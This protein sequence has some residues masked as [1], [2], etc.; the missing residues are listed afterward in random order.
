M[1][2]GLDIKSFI[3]GAIFVWFVFPWIMGMLNRNKAPK[4]AS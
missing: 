4:N 1:P 3:V 2:F